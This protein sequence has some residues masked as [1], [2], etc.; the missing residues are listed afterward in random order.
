MMNL[1][2]KSIAK[3]NDLCNRLGMDTISCGAT[4]A[5][6]M[7]AYEKGH[8]SKESL[9][10]LDMSW[11]NIDSVIELIH[12]IAYR[13]EFGD[14]AAEG[15]YAL[16]KNLTEE[17]EG[18][19]VTVKKLELPMHDP[20][21]F[22]GMG[23]AYMMS[24]RGA[25]H[26]QHSCQAVEQGLVDWGEADLKEDYEGPSSE[27]KAQMVYVS[28]NIGQMANTICVCHFVHWAI[29]MDNLTKTSSCS[30]ELTVSTSSL[31]SDSKIREPVSA[32]AFSII[33]LINFDRS[34]SSMISLEIA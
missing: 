33:I 27:G 4:I 25:C 23:L 5:F 15:S 7:E 14:K 12:K 9:D 2:L 1:N 6:I 8:L 34:L 22:H 19:L 24:T 32:P 28:E 20:R 31:P 16:A 26:L 3:A 30:T 29:G 17:S 21:G 13:Q 11:G 10:G 18:Y